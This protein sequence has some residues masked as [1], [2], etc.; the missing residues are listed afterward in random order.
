M[1]E[2]QNLNAGIPAFDFPTQFNTNPVEPA[3]IASPLGDGSLRVAQDIQRKYNPNK[4]DLSKSLL[5]TDSGSMWDT[6]TTKKPALEVWDRNIDQAYVQ[7]NDGTYKARF[8]NYMSGVNN[9]NRLALQQG[10]GEKLLNGVGKFVTK[11]GVNVLDAT[12]GTVNGLL[13]GISTGT[14]NAIYNNDFAKWIDDVN[15]KLDIDLPNYYS[16]Q[17][18]NNSLISN[19]ATTNFWAD[20]VLGGMSFVTGTLISEGIWAAATGGTS[21]ATAGSRALLRGGASAIRNENKVLHSITSMMN[22]YQRTVPTSRALKAFNNAR[23]LYTSAGYEAG[24]E[25]RH[26]LKEAEKNYLDYYSNTFGGTPSGEEMARFRDEATVSS[27]TLFAANVALVGGSNIAQFGNLFGVGSFLS[28]RGLQRGF[29]RTLGIGTERVLEG[30]VDTYRAINPTRVQR[31]LGTS[32]NVLKSPIREGV[33]EEGGQSVLGN[34]GQ[35]YLESK[36]DANAVQD[37]FST[38]D[39]LQKSLAQTYGTK[40]G[41]EEVLIGSLIGGLSNVKSGFG[42]RDYQKAVDAQSDIATWQTT[43][44]NYNLLEKF[45]TAN[46]QK[47]AR[48]KIANSIQDGVIANQEL[49]LAVFS[50]LQLDDKMGLL[51]N[52]SENFISSINELDINELSEQLNVSVEE[53]TQ[54]KQEALDAHTSALK[55]YKEAQRYAEALMPENQTLNIDGATAIIPNVDAQS[56]LALNIYMGRNSDRLARSYAKGISDIIGNEGAASALSLEN[57]LQAKEVNKSKEVKSLTRQLEI[58]DRDLNSRNEELIRIASRP[59][60]EQGDA[61]LQAFENRRQELLL[62]EER[63]SK[64]RNEINSELEAIAQDINQVRKAK[65][66]A[67][68]EFANIFDDESVNAEKLVEATNNLRSLSETLDAWRRNGQESSAEGVGYMIDQYDKAQKAFVNANETFN[69]LSNPALRKAEIKTIFSPILNK[70][71]KKG[72]DISDYQKAEQEIYQQLRNQYNEFKVI[73]DNANTEIQSPQAKINLAEEGDSLPPIEQQV[74]TELTAEIEETY[75]TR[76]EELLSQQQIELTQTEGLLENSEEYAQIQE[77]HIQQLNALEQQRDEEL[78]QNSGITLNTPQT[79]RERLQSIVDDILQNRRDVEE[80][81]TPLKRPSQQE[82]DEYKKLYDRNRRSVNG[83]REKDSQR[84]NQLKDRLNTYGRAVGT[85]EGGV[86]LADILEQIATLDEVNNNQ[87]ESLPV[88]NT[89]TEEIQASLT[90]AGGRRDTA[91]KTQY[92]EKSEFRVLENGTYSITGINLQ[93]LVDIVAKDNLVGILNNKPNKRNNRKQVSGLLTGE[94]YNVGDRFIIQFEDGTEINVT[95]GQTKGLEINAAG[96]SILNESTRFKA[97][98]STN[99]GTNYQPLLIELNRNA[100]VTPLEINNSNFE[101]EPGLTFTDFTNKPDDTETSLFVSNRNEFNKDLIQKFRAGAISMQELQNN[102]SIYVMSEEGEVG[103]VL[104][105]VPREIFEDGNY[106][107]LSQIRKIATQRALESNLENDLID[108]QI[109]VP[110]DR[111]SSYFGKPNFN[112]ILDKS[113]GI[114]ATELLPISNK[115]LEKI[116][117][118]GYISNEKLTLKVNEKGVNTTFVKRMSRG[119]KFPIVVFNY[120]GSKVAYPVSMNEIEIDKVGEFDNLLNADLPINE[121]VKGLNQYLSENNIDSNNLEN[122]FYY[123]SGQTN[124]NDPD[125]LDSI[126]DQLSSQSSYNNFE[127]W[128]NESTIETAKQLLQQQASINIDITDKPFHS[129]KLALKLKERV[130][131]GQTA[132]PTNTIVEETTNMAQK[133]IQDNTCA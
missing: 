110:I 109:S 83:L 65:R 4:I 75:N 61:R 79:L 116:V 5:S 74:P 27:N 103:G 44:S 14:F 37:S 45:K 72:A 80:L 97:I 22:A 93:G 59:R 129:P 21:L 121:K 33:I 96:I 41:L 115:A 18:K 12:V 94:N 125:H 10:A 40:E 86:V 104:K 128:V 25:A 114:L 13:E 91:N 82:M 48:G 11:T 73:V 126:R 108:V 70:F 31:I 32:L 51:D 26:F 54:I 127:D 38:M 64:R 87:T 66:I 28:T 42:I 84:F 95:I 100:T 76:R 77:R 8:E 68:Q 55:D 35:R 69:K 15:T 67:N 101:L 24:V 88:N 39:A 90:L 98:P 17:E 1:D 130:I 122:G 6:T 113:T 30:V 81:S 9:E 58:L 34:F 63:D 36:Y 85:V 131:I 71:K 92:W 132:N 112:L 105:S 119:R 120:N 111:N 7:L 49:N 47:A 102:I 124:L 133:E 123:I 60:T 107:E 43:N 89:N 106:L 23:F 20:K 16:E 2:I 50:K 46:V 19:L 56:V 78:F 117:D 118:V 3:T 57:S 62:A 53:A 29:N 52:S 99:L